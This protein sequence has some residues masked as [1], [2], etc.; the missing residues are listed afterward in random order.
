MKGELRGFFGWLNVD[1]KFFGL[2]DWK[3]GVVVIRNGEGCRL[4]RLNKRIWSN[5]V[6]CI[7][8]KEKYVLCFYFICFGGSGF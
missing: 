1:D 2:S 3:D 6:W 5:R 7:V 4:R 8:F